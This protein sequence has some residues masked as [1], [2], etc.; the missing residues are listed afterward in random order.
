ME[1]LSKCE[2]CL[3]Q[4]GENQL[5]QCL[6]CTKRFCRQ[7]IEPCKVFFKK[8]LTLTGD[9]MES[10]DKCDFCH[11]QFAEYQLIRCFQCDKI[12]CQKCTK[13]C[14]VF[15]K[16]TCGELELVMHYC[17]PKCRRDSGIIPGYS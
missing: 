14:Q 8:T 4:F 3:Q 13:P 1:S 7:C 6:H 5:I 15:L 11:K 2:F 17:T 12:F 9:E 16:K 10:L